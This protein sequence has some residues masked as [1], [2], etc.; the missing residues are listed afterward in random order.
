MIRGENERSLCMRATLS[1]IEV[2]CV[3]AVGGVS[4]ARG[5]SAELEARLPGM[6]GR[7][8]YGATFDPENDCRARV[9]LR[10]GDPN[11]LGLETWTIPGGACERRKIDNRPELI[12]GAFE[13]MMAEHP[14]DTARPSI[15]FY[16]SQK[17]I[18]FFWPVREEPPEES[19]GIRSRVPC[20][21]RGP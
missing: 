6:R 7:K 19:Y 14:G 9:A 5:A 8:F 13:E 3:V 2:M 18:T 1:D 11:A 4:G 12:A 15:E 17:E 10:G 21:R 16:R 20:K